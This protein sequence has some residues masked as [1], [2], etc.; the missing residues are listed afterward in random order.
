MVHIVL[1]YTHTHIYTADT[2]VYRSEIPV[3]CGKST[4]ASSLHLPFRTHCEIVLFHSCNATRTRQK[5]NQQQQKQREKK[6]LK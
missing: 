2:G 4:N 6:L 5:T 3:I 1:S